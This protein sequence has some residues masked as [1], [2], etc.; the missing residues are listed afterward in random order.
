MKTVAIVQARMTSTRLPGKILADLA[1]APMLERQLSRMRRATTLDDVMIATTTNTSD[2]PVVALCDRLGISTFR[3]SEDDVLSRYAG[4]A[5]SS[6]ADVVVRITADCPLLDGGVVDRVVRA[7]YAEGTDYASNTI[8]RS[9]P[10]GLDVEALTREALDRTA[11]AAT[12][13]PAREHVTWF[14]HTENPDAFM[15]SSVACEVDASDLRWTV[16]TPDDLAMVRA[17]YAGLGLANR[18]VPYPEIVAWVRAHPEVVR[19][20]AGV[21]QK[22]H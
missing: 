3:G 21:P 11:A 10:R 16:D 9:Y 17:V 19:L 7:L 18:H 4:A 6:N 15:R 2:D 12:S 14:I 20:N 5:A 1:G 8:T 22:I 13:K